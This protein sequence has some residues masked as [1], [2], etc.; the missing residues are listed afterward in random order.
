MT[1]MEIAQETGKSERGI[2]AYLTRRGVTIKDYDRA[3]KREKALKIAE[4]APIRRRHG[5][6]FCEARPAMGKK[7]A[8]RKGSDDPTGIAGTSPDVATARRTETQVHPGISNVQ[9]THYRF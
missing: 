9:R 4:A 2:K 5:D 8:L 6:G 7:A 1:L 3:G